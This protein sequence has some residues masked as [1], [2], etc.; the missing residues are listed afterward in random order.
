MTDA[1]GGYHDAHLVTP[2]ICPGPPGQLPSGISNRHA[3]L[4]DSP[5]RPRRLLYS[6]SLRRTRDPGVCR[7]S[8]SRGAVRPGLGETRVNPCAQCPGYRYPQHTKHTPKTHTVYT[9]ACVRVPVCLHGVRCVCVCV[10]VYL[11]VFV[12]VCVCVT[13][14]FLKQSHGVRYRA[15]PLDSSV[16][17]AANL[18]RPPHAA[19]PPSQHNSKAMHSMRAPLPRSP[20]PTPVQWPLWAGLRRVCVCVC[21]CVRAC[22]RACLCVWCVCVCVCVCPSTPLCSR[23]T[24][25]F[26]AGP[27]CLGCS[28]ASATLPM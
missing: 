14:R 28:E 23:F 22:L 2:A 16:R 19:F 9:C 13:P 10:F 20:V 15:S 18:Y 17:S 3:E 25:S 1:E 11:S 4:T 24:P 27:A 8:P 21:V 5:L 12:C 7:Q 26:A 6:E